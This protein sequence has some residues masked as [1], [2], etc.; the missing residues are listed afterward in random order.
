MRGKAQDL[1][2]P[3]PLIAHVQSPPLDGTAGGCSPLAN[4][5]SPAPSTS[6]FQHLNRVLV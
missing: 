2:K 1:C 5:P 3:S 4:L 6:D